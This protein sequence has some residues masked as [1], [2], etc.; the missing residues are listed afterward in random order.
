[1]STT[2]RMLGVFLVLVL[3]LV[4]GGRSLANSVGC[5]YE[6]SPKNPPNDGI[7]FVDNSLAGRSGHLGHAVVE[8]A[9]GKVLAFYPNSSVDN[10]GH[11]AVGWME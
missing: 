4:H 11:S 2:L 1:M 3:S 7:L 6:L 10:K 9:D 8:Y 5:P